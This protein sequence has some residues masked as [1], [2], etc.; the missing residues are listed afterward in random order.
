MKGLPYSHIQ[1]LISAIIIC[2]LSLQYRP[3][4]NVSK[5]NHTAYNLSRLIL[6]TPHNALG[7]HLGGCVFSSFFIAE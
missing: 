2:S 5:W 6:S 3:F 4:K 1:P 7:I